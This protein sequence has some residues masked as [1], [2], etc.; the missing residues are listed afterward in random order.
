MIEAN[1]MSEWFF[2]FESVTS[3]PYTLDYAKTFAREHQGAYCWH[4]GLP[5]WVSVYEAIEIRPMK[6]DG[7]TPFPPMPAHMMSPK[8]VTLPVITQSVN[9]INTQ[10]AVIETLSSH[11]FGQQSVTEALIIKS[12]D[13]KC[14]LWKL[15]WI[16][17]RVQ[18]QKQER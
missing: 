1:T 12:S 2:S 5:D 9:P 6:K 15:S 8:P 17:K 4:Q 7:V 14:S 3:G 10:S 16:H 11:G 13:M 18:S